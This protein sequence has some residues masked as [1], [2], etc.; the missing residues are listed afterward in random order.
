MDIKRNDYFKCSQITPPNKDPEM[1]KLEILQIWKD[2]T[3]RLKNKRGA[4]CEKKD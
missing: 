2:E 3:L 4:S 1:T